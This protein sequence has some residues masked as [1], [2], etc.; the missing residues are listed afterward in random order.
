MSQFNSVIYYHHTLPVILSYPALC[1]LNFSH[2][3]TFALISLHLPSI[4]FC[5]IIHHLH[6]PVI[7]HGH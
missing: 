6:T 1:G 5:Y 4:S 2:T 3:H 7:G